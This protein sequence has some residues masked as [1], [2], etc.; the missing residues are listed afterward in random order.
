MDE[1]TGGVFFNAPEK[2]LVG[3]EIVKNASPQRVAEHG[4]YPSGLFLKLRILLFCSR[5]GEMGFG[6]LLLQMCNPERIRCVLLIS[7]LESPF[8]IVGS[9]CELFSVELASALS[10]YCIQVKRVFSCQD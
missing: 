9:R 5:R 2:T 10:G 7:G 6:K 4:D 1:R 8:E 3:P